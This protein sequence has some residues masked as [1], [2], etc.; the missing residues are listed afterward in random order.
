MASKDTWFDLL[1]NAKFVTDV[2]FYHR[3]LKVCLQP[4]VDNGITGKPSYLV[5]DGIYVIKFRYELLGMSSG[6][7][8]VRQGL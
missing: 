4:I 6:N 5:C 7:K 1:G 8:S 2:R 3:A